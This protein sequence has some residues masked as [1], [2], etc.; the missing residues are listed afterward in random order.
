MSTTRWK[1]K[2]IERDGPA[3]QECGSGENLA[4][5]HVWPK[6]LGGT[7][8]P[9]NLQLLCGSCNSK[10]RCKTP[11]VLPLYVEGDPWEAWEVHRAKVRASHVAAQEGAR[12]YWA[13]VR[14][15]EQR[16]GDLRRISR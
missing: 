6:V 7:D 14:S 4:V 15:G 12:L 8:H 3:C 11:D 1:Q 10:K 13:R 16:H 5:D 9:Y 2:L